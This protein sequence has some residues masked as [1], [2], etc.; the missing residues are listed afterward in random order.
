MS[1]WAKKPL[2]PQLNTLV[3]RRIN[4]EIQRQGKQLPCTVAAVVSSGI[5]TVNFEVN[6]APA[7]L[8]QVTIPIVGSEWV[9]YPIQVGDKGAVIA[10]DVR[11]GGI[12][13]LGSGTPTMVRPGNLSALA[14]LWLGNTGW[15]PTDDV[16][17]V[18]LYGPNGVVL[19][20]KASKHKITVSQTD[21]NIDGNIK[22]NGN[23]LAFFGGT[24][25]SKA[26]VVGSLSAVSD[27]N[28]K[29]VLTS[30][31]ALISTYNLGT[32]GTT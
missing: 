19:R 4:D 29:A 26:T 25:A 21:V 18:V 8:P 30:I 20:D 28:A 14:F 15:S 32:N 5:V 31:L 17:A 3:L 22:V 7:T 2:G 1:D 9:R 27:A 16:N 6:A 24:E 11:L 23:K 10:F 12:T 13:G